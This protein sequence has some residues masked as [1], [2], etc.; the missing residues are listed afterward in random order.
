MPPPST[1]I[2]RDGPASAGLTMRAPVD[3]IGVGLSDRTR[4]VCN[5]V[6]RPRT[7]VEYDIALA[8]FADKVVAPIRASRLAFFWR[9]Q[10]DT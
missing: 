3:L 4:P 10:I 2:R 6:D 8:D 5:R 1:P 9:V 7:V